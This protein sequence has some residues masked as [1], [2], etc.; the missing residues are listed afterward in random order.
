RLEQEKNLE[1]KK[2]LLEKVR[3]IASLELKSAKKWQDKSNDIIQIQKEWKMIGFVPKAQSGEI[4][5]EF[6][7]LCDAFFTKKREH[8]ES[9]RGV[10]SENKEKKVALLNKAIELKD[11]EDWKET[12][13]A[14]IQLQKQWK[15]IGPAHQRDENKLW[16]QFREACDEFF[17]KRNQHRAGRGDREQENLKAKEEILKELEAWTP[18]KGKRQENITKLREFGDR[19]RQIGFVP[20]SE[21]DR[22]GSTYK[23][24][25]DEK[26]G[27][28]DMDANERKKV[29]LEEKIESIKSSDK[30][31]FLLRKEREFVQNKISKLQGD[32]TQFENNMGFFAASKGA[33]KLKEDIERKIA[34]TRKEIDALKEQLS[35]IKNA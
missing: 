29:R 15:E 10:Q 24:L 31:D 3:H 1:S 21:K 14:L 17:Q 13:N 2:L 28:L 9:L 35:L 5:K 26:Y 12:S 8:F 20:F 7:S 22:I 11:S 18:E 23:K 34:K 16:R 32:I 4:W 33:D 25:L 30:S 27:A 19:Y 6:K